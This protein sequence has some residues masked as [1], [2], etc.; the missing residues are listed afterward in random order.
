MKIPHRRVYRQGSFDSTFVLILLVILAQKFYL[1]ILYL[2]FL[3]HPHFFR[4]ALFGD[5]AFIQ[6]EVLDSN[7]LNAV[8]VPP[9]LD[10]VFYN[11]DFLKGIR[12]TKQ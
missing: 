10:V 7:V 3:R 11:H 2:I 6:K 4:Y 5:E 12:D 9:R 1:Y 8:F